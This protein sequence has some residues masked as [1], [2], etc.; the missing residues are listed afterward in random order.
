MYKH[1]QSLYNHKRTC[2]FVQKKD[3]ENSIISYNDN[4]Q[5]SLI[6]TEL[7]KKIDEKDKTI[8]EKDKT[9]EEKDKT[10]KDMIK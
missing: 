7:L 10:I 6:I 8:D 1:N 9:I 4:S 2:D 5:N 3:T